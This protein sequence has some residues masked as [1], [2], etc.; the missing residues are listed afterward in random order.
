MSS[1]FQLFPSYYW[2]WHQEEVHA[3][4]RPRPCQK[5]A[6]FHVV[7]PFRRSRL[8]S[9]GTS[10]WQRWYIKDSISSHHNV[11][12]IYVCCLLMTIMQM[13]VTVCIVFCNRLW[14]CAIFHVHFHV[15]IIHSPRLFHLPLMQY[16]LAGSRA[17]S[18]WRRER[19]C[20]QW[21]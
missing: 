21:K 1:L 7:Q 5:E 16:H 15:N 11:T 6:S 9:G 13:W 18:K 19:Y 3:V 20:Q 17:R 4:S 12:L 10:N 8:L 2:A 14:Q